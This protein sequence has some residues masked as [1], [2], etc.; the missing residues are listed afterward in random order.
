MATKL[1][2]SVIQAFG[3]SVKEAMRRDST[4][5]LYTCNDDPQEKALRWVMGQMSFL[6][7]HAYGPGSGGGG[8][9]EKL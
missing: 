4:G 8:D 1:P 3:I 9:A 6:G 7:D 2:G 5:N